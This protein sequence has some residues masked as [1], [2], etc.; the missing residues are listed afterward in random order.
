MTPGFK[1][2]QTETTMASSRNGINAFTTNQITPQIVVLQSDSVVCGQLTRLYAQ[3]AYAVTLAD[4]AEAALQELNEQSVDLL[5]TDISPPDEDGIRFIARV[6][7][8]YSDVPVIVISRYKDIESAVRV[9]KLGVCDYLTVPFNAEALQDST[10]GALQKA[11]IFTE[12]RHMR[13]TIGENY[14]YL[15]MVSKTPEMQKVFET[16]RMVSNMDV[17]VLVEGETGTG[18]ELVARA[19]HNRSG[20][21]NGKLVVINCAGVPEALLESELFGY[22]KGA[23]TSA[24]HSK[25]GMIELAHGGTL[26]LDEIESM[27]FSMQAKL[28]RVLEDKKV[29]RL[30]GNR[31]FPIDMRVIATTNVAA[32]DLVDQGKMRADFYYRINVVSIQLAP[33]RQRRGDIPL[34][35]QNYLRKHP[36]AVQKGIT[37]ISLKAMR[38]LMRYPWPGNIRELQNVLEKAIVLSPTSMIEDVD[39]PDGLSDI[40][41]DRE[42]RPTGMSFSQ[43]IREQ[44][45]AYL[46]HQLE[47]CHGRID[48]TAANSGINIRTLFRKM[49]EYG[50]DKKQFNGK[51]E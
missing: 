33:L 8:S 23:F 5:V 12:L 39:L 21:H 19:I 45:K 26:F 10:R 32:K 2:R 31:T 48:Q 25:A 34:L 35:V 43:W 36:F 28:L 49:R 20:R 16:I 41:G 46:V 22:E 50:L 24:D 1:E 11:R 29:Q 17:T 6:R 13:R 15:G 4:T 14:E 9:L 37:E 38:Q 42:A 7:Q 47:A 27:S 40:R 51:L 3:C 18:K 44:E 30:G